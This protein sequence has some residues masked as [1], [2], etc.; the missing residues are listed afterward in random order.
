M[1]ETVFN[2][3]KIAFSKCLL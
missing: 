3:M 2:Y 1:I